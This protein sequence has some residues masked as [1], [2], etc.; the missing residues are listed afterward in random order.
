MLSA[1]LLVL[2]YARTSRLAFSSP[3]EIPAAISSGLLLNEWL[4]GNQDDASGILCFCQLISC[5]WLLEAAV[6]QERISETVPLRSSPDCKSESLFEIMIRF[7]E[8]LFF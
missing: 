2:E 8:T 3:R 4:A 5:V 7:L 1:A 6:H